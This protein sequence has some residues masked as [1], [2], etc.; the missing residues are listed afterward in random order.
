[1]AAKSRR[2]TGAGDGSGSGW[3]SAGPIGAQEDEGHEVLENSGESA[4][5]L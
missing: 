3:R 2:M 5:N 4:D 1:M